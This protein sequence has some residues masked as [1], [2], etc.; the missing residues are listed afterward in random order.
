MSTMTRSD[1]ARRPDTHAG[2]SSQQVDTMTHFHEVLFIDPGVSDIGTLLA[3]VRPEVEAIVLRSTSPAAR[4]MAQ[5]L[6]G[7]RDLDAVHLIA[8]GSPGRVELS[9]GAW[10]RGSLASQAGDLAGIGEALG[11]DGELRLWSCETG[12]GEA[13]DS[14]VAELSHVIGADVRAASAKI[15][16]AEFGG[17]WNLARAPGAFTAR[18]PLSADGQARYA[19]VFA[20]EI[21]ISGQIKNGPTTRNVTYF[22]LDKSSNAVVGNI[23]LPDASTFANAFRL[24]VAVPRLSEIFGV[25]TFDETGNFVSAGFQ[26]EVPEPPTGAVGPRR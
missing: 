11:A 18:Q 15:G 26:I 24:Q 9:G 5:V 12:F 7:R 13:G 1:A 8:H 10:S 2:H 17:S 19:S 6:A 16:A 21:T 22:V 23:T 14:F 20:V 3:G 4:Q 25:G